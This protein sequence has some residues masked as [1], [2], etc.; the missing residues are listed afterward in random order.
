MSLPLVK[1]IGMAQIWATEM[2]PEMMKAQ[3]IK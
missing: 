1:G 3:E 2:S